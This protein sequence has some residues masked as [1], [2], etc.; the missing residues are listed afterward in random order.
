[1]ESL[2][3]AYD[4]YGDFN[5]ELAFVNYFNLLP[6][7]INLDLSLKS[8]N[9]ST[10]NIQEALEFEA[11]D[12]E[13]VSRKWEPRNPQNKQESNNHYSSFYYKSN[14]KKLC[15]WLS[16]YHEGLSLEFLYDVK[17]LEL[18]KWV[19]AA[20]HKVKALFGKEEGAVFQVL[21]KR[22]GCEFYTEEVDIHPTN[23][24]IATL[25]NDDFLE[26]DQ[27]IHKS[28]E[29]HSS[30]LMLFHG[31]PG[32][33][34]TS[35]IKYLLNQHRNINFIFVPNDFVKEIL[36]PEFISFLINHKNSVLVIEDA[37][38]VITSRENN[39]NSVV[40][41]ILQL[42]D[43]LFSDYLNIKII[44]TFNISIEKVDPALLRKGRMIAFHE[45]IALSLE[46]T[47]EL[48]ASL[49]QPPSE[50]ELTL[51]DIFN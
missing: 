31:P 10:N 4:L 17:D 43:G 30:G 23:L 33:G 5:K 34:K 14:T 12:I 39:Q 35:Y 16:L 24:D 37:E 50:K 47:N 18:E 1:M 22:N 49:G 8:K 25:Y 21:A 32:T 20:Y 19:V 6:S 26:I 36:Q 11:Y 13:V 15:I 9:I 40:S 41:T 27:A 3:N 7:V 45:F 2:L 51:A 44:C 28:L 29:T 42:T 48:L 46:K 38:K